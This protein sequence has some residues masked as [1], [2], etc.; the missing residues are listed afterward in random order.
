MPQ[1]GVYIGCICSCFEDGSRRGSPYAA[2]PLSNPGV[3]AFSR[4]KLERSLFFCS[5]VGGYINV[6]FVAVM[7]EGCLLLLLPL[8]ISRINPITSFSMALQ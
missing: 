2:G 6:N 4:M 1:K 7:A 3:M 8:E 5:Y